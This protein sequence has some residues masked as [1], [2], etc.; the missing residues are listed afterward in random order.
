[1]K[2]MISNKIVFLRFISDLIFGL[3]H[4]GQNKSRVIMS[5]YRMLSEAVLDRSSH[6]LGFE[7]QSDR[8]REVR[9]AD[10]W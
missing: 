5:S 2:K 1:M 3:F 7:S 9:L 10:I 4:D 6:F 8:I